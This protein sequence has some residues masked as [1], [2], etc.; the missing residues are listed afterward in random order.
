MRLYLPPNPATYNPATERDRTDALVRALIP[1]V[2]Q[3]EAVPYIHLRAP[4]DGSIWRVETDQ[5]G[6]LRTVKVSG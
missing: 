4:E 5:H 6:V 3:D 1:V 2:S